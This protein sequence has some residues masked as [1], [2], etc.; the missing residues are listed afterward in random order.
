MSQAQFSPAPL[1]ASFIRGESTYTPSS[2]GSQLGTLIEQSATV[3]SRLSVKMDCFAEEYSSAAVGSTGVSRFWVKSN[4]SERS[5]SARRAGAIVGSLIGV[6]AV[7]NV[8]S[9]NC[10]I[11]VWSSR[12]LNTVFAG[13]QGDT[14]KSGVRNAGPT[15]FPPSGKWAGTFSRMWG[16]AG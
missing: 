12:P 8:R 10:S 2:C 9:M 3:R 13:A 14:T 6:R 1:V 7:E 15:A 16:G 11:E 4:A 5:A